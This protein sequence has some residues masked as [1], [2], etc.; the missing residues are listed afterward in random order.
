MVMKGILPWA[1]T[2]PSTGQRDVLWAEVRRLQHCPSPTE[3]SYINISLGPSRYC[4]S[5]CRYEV[6]CLRA[7]LSSCKRIGGFKLHQPS[8]HPPHEAM[9]SPDS[10]IA[11]CLDRLPILSLPQLGTAPI[12]APSFTYLYC[13]YPPKE[14]HGF[15][16]SSS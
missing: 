3:K 16:S 7:C 9:L 6:R 5:L 12:W 2:P 10:L 1:A 14:R 8:S 15:P 11:T 13:V 4:I